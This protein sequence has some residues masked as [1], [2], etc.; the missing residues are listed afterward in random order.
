MM[1]S[2]KT[3]QAMSVAMSILLYAGFSSADA[4]NFSGQ[5]AIFLAADSQATLTG[6]TLDSDADGA[7]AVFATGQQAKITA[8]HL[9]I[10]TKNNSSRG[11]DATYGGTITAND[12]DITTE[13][14]HCAALA[15]DRGEG[16]I[17]VS[18]ATLKTSGDG[19]PCVYSTGN[20]QLSK[21]IGEATGS[22]IAVV[23]GKNSI[24]L[25][26]VNLTGHKKHGIMLYQSFSGDA[27]VG[28]AT[29]TATDSQLHNASDGPMFFITNT[30]ATA[31]LTRTQ[32]Q[33]SGSTLVS[34]T[35]AR[36][37]TTGQNG[38]NFTLNTTE[39]TLT[40]D[41]LANNISEL[42]I[43]LGDKTTWTG[44]INSDNQAKTANLTLAATATWTLT[45]DAYVTTF[46]DA[47]ADYSNIQ[48]QGHNIYYSK[49]SNPKLNGK[50]IPLPDG[51]QL[52]AK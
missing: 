29:F 50:T 52:I 39:Q 41:I 26:K 44:T 33:Q 17:S 42:H 12:V 43:N 2:K 45:A 19:S 35:S 13:G 1:S 24:T 23:E 25:N 8:S 9:K 7:N 6:V 21:A 18:D 22:E 31:N 37:G 51:G 14:Q 16:N 34:V 5:N 11:L 38:G 40:G 27:G 28:N 30:T 36:W 32:L 3:Y 48:S 47:Q 10:H 15:T 49:A 4:S 20:I 46:S